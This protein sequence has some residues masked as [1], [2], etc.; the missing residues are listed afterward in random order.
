MRSGRRLF[1]IVVAILLSL[2]VSSGS[3]ELTRVPVGP[4][5]I[6]GI[7]GLAVT[8]HV[9]DVAALASGVGGLAATPEGFDRGPRP[10]RSR[11]E[12]LAPD[13]PVR[14]EESPM[15]TEEPSRP[16]VPS[17]PLELGFA[18]LDSSAV[19]ISPPDT[20]G[21][22]GL[23]DVA[24]M[25]NTQFRIQ[26]RQGTER[27]TV[28]TG[29][30]WGTPSDGFVLD[31]RLL[32]DRSASRWLA[33]AIEGRGLFGDDIVFHTLLV[34][35][36]Q[37]EDA[38]GSWN[39]YRFAVDSNPRANADFPV[40]GYSRDRVVIHVAIDYAEGNQPSRLFVFAKAALLSGIAAAPTMI[41]FGP[42]HWAVPSVTTDPGLTTVYLLEDWDGN[43]VDGGL[44]KLSAITGEIGAESL[45]TIAYPATTERWAEGPSRGFHSF[46]PQKGSDELIEMPGSRV[47]NVLYRNGSLWAVQTIYLPASAPNA[48]AIQWWEITLD[49]TVRQRG[50]IQDSTGTFFY[51]YPSIAVNRDNDVLIGFARFSRDTYP[52]G[53]Y[54]YRA[55]GDPPGAF[56]AVAVLRDGEAP[57]TR[58]SEGGR[59]RWG[60]YSA[61]I[62]DPVTDR[63]FWT[64]QEYSI[65]PPPQVPSGW[66]TWWGR[67]DAEA[68]LD[69]RPALQ[70]PRRPRT[71]RRQGPWPIRQNHQVHVAGAMGVTKVSLSKWHFARYR[72]ARLP[73]ETR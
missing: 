58:K 46:A 68:P 47:S 16:G 25:L 8:P 52:G 54:A 45:A 10:P 30:F 40:L 71:V 64:L 66:G 13:A 26:D 48:A 44:L 38:G 65:V 57:Y 7:R 4:E 18:A 67:I 63:D 28:L 24:T 36:S 53:G 41:S 56:R 9:V 72:L 1:L 20:N 69:R 5:P 42:F 32:F 31:P 6:R 27:R 34:A 15:T 70:P 33:T 55:G 62:V 22:V 35:A 2:Q 17:P 21:G 12:A 73:E 23:Q 51:G 37:T 39:V 19:M 50:R 43:G 61:T 11:E 14:L 49:G 59:V 3:A 60:D 29:E